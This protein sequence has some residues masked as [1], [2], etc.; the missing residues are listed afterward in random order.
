MALKWGVIGASGIADRR[1]IPEAIMPSD[2]AELVALLDATMEKAREIGQKYGVENC[3]DDPQKFLAMDEIEAVYIGTP[4]HLH[5][6]EVIACANAGKHVLCEKPLGLT[7]REC[8]NMI[9]ACQ[10][11][12]VKLMVGYMMRFHAHHQKLKQMIDNGD[13]GQPVF[14]RAEL[15][16]WY[17]EIEGAWRQDLK[18]SGGGALMDMGTHCIDLLRMLLGEVTQVTAFMDTLTFKYPLEDTATVLLKFENGAQG[19]VD[20]M[21]NVPD[22]A[23][24]NILEIYGTQGVVIADHTVG[25]DAG[26]NM[27]AYLTG[28]AGE[29]DASQVREGE[30]LGRPVEVEPINM[31]RAEVEHFTDCIEQ[32]RE[33]LITGEE[34]IKILRIALA[35]YESARS[36]KTI[37]V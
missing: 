31:Y 9:E 17:P 27:T 4:V 30:D 21:F 37:K 34:A 29:Y 6:E 1:T 8:E 11:N 2:Q 33:P 5:E 16:C 7:V 20:N 22:A 25:Q 26:G 10:R 28:P 13:L 14:G 19:L 23:A 35:A 18:L 32:N 15:T 24:Q 12:G 36:G 3:L